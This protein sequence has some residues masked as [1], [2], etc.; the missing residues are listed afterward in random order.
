M[1]PLIAT[2]AFIT[3]CGGRQDKNAPGRLETRTQQL[4][5]AP[6]TVIPL[7]VETSQ[8]ERGSEQAVLEMIDQIDASRLPW[9]RSVHDQTL[10]MVNSATRGETPLHR[11]N[12][13]PFC[14][15]RPDENTL[16]VSTLD[17]P[18]L[19]RVN[20]LGLIPEGIVHELDVPEVMA[21]AVKRGWI[22][23]H[24]AE[25]IINSQFRSFDFQPLVA[26]WLLKEWPVP[27]RPYP[28]P[29]YEAGDVTV[30]TEDSFGNLKLNV[31]PEEF[32]YEEG[33]EVTLADD[34]T[35]ICVRS[36]KDVPQGTP[37]QPILAITVGSSGLRN[38]QTGKDTRFLEL[39]A[40][41]DSA[42][43]ITAFK[44]GDTAILAKHIPANR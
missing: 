4:V 8:L 27:S 19:P 33:L 24:E 38:P 30:F 18:V 35:A 6:I 9:E 34:T 29:A 40:M 17:G 42:H 7:E 32:G 11:P 43:K 10:I 5:G 3:D 20:S 22:R 13:S 39:V 1:K 37:E 15:W 2:G 31:T 26:Y 23:D 44:R 16:V 28:V 21:H 36:L 12:G 25:R 14:W 41:K